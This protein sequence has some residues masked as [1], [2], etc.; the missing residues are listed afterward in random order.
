MLHE[1]LLAVDERGT[2]AAA[3]TAVVMARVGTVAARPVP[4]VVDRPYL[5]VMHTAPDGVPLVVV[6]VVDPL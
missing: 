4:F 2:E 6:R 3:A 1:A 5:V